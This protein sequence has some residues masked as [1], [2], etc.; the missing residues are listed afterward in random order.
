MEKRGIQANL[1]LCVG[2]VYFCSIA[3]RFNVS[4]V[5]FFKDSMS[6]TFYD[7]DSTEAEVVRL[8]VASITECLLGAPANRRLVLRRRLNVLIDRHASRLVAQ[9][10]VGGAQAH[11]RN[12]IA[13]CRRYA[14]HLRLT[15][16]QQ[17]HGRVLEFR[18]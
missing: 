9:I 2:S 1:L 3:E 4:G 17:I 11:C 5:T 16:W 14:P 7:P 18:T 6:G 13:F 8:Y 10:G 15:I 12:R